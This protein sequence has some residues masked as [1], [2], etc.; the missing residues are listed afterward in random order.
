MAVFSTNQNRQL[1]VLNAFANNTGENPTSVDETSAV[2]TVE[3]KTVGT[4]ADKEVFFVYKGADTVLRSDR[5]PVKNLEYAKAVSAA[6]MV[7]PL[8]VVK[9][10]LDSEVN[11]GAPIKGQD[12]LLRV[13]LR[14]F[15]GMSDQDQ[16]FKEAVVHVTSDMVS[17]PLKFYQALVKSLNQ[18]FAREVGANAT[19][20][21][22]L[23]F[24]ADATGVTIT[25]KAQEW[26]LGTQ[27]QERV[28]FDVFPTTVYSDGDDVVWGTVTDLTPSKSAAVVGTTGIGNGTKIAD[29]E[30]FCMGERGDQ[31]RMIG[32]PNN[33]PTKYLVDPSQQYNVLEIHYSF[34]DTGVNSYKSEKDIT[35]VATNKAVINSVVGALNTATGL[36]IATI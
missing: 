32:W 19:S 36:N 18:N 15:Y 22:Y 24:T 33:I 29:L 31:Y 35:L 11:G 16:Y 23:A 14:Q 27:S 25:E 3:V 9:V 4:G 26:T 28:Y 7:T 21:P 6:D 10:A 2:G 8:K 12:Y 17:A 30:W 5:I 13:V 34:T 1:Y 20:N